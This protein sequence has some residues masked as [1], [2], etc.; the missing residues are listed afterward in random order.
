MQI[1]AIDIAK[2]TFAKETQVHLAA[3]VLDTTDGT[4]SLTASAC[5]PADA[6]ERDLTEAFVSDA[7][8]QLG[9]LPGYRSGEKTIAFADGALP[10]LR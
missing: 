4:V 7:I 6:S 3:V 1:R 5:L 8:R 10:S 2:L 9:R